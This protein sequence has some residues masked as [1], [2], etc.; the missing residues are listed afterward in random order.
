MNA[1]TKDPTKVM[2]EF[3]SKQRQKALRFVQNRRSGALLVI[4]RLTM[5]LCVTFLRGILKIAGDAWETAQ[6]VGALAGKPYSCR[7][8]EAHKG[9]LAP[10]VRSRAS[11]LLSRPS[12]WGAVLRAGWTS[13]CAAL[14]FFDGCDIYV[15]LGL[16]C[17]YAMGGDALPFLVVA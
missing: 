5:S 12:E 4:M 11:L 3:N 9:R 13:G 15:W 14:A 17:F 6:Q 1:V 16:S 7:M 8:F 2:S 10:Q